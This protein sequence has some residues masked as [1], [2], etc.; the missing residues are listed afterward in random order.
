MRNNGSV[1][2]GAEGLIRLWKAQPVTGAT[3]DMVY[4]VLHEGILSGILSPGQ[5]LA[6]EG[7]AALFSV[8]R[9]PVREALVRL[10]TTGLAHRVP[11]RGLVVGQIT[12]QEIVEVYVVRETIDGL[13][14]F[15]AA[16]FATPGDVAHL[17]SLNGEFARAVARGDTNEMARLNL[18]FHTAV[19]AAA[20]NSLL[21][22]FLEQIHQ[23]VRRF[24]GTTFQHPERAEG[25]VEEHEQL[26]AAIRAGDAERAR[27]IA[28]ESMATARRIRIAMLARDAEALART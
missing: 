13:A 10:E 9:T 16:Q 2:A 25:A 4:A 21:V 5:R 3:S 18:V 28:S 27:T 23:L 14:A 8:S 19:A 1:P 12:P 7:L 26:I 17:T 20:R 22:Q 11:R 15:L 24:P 6:E